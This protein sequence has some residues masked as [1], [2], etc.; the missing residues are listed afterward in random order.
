MGAQVSENKVYNDSKQKNYSITD[1]DD[2]DVLRFQTSAGQVIYNPFE[3]AVQAIQGVKSREVYDQVKT[4][5]VPRYIDIAKVP[6][7]RLQPGAEAALCWLLKNEVMENGRG[8]WPYQYSVDFRG[9][10]I[11]PPWVCSFGQSYA[12]L[13]FLLWFQHSQNSEYLEAACRAM[14]TVVTPLAAVGTKSFLGRGVFFEELPND[15]HIFNAHLLSLIVLHKLYQ[16]GV[17]EFQ[18]DFQEGIIGFEYLASFMDSGNWSNYDVPKFFDRQFQCRLS[19][20]LKELLIEKLLIIDANGAHNANSVVHD[21]QLAAAAWL[22]GAHLRQGNK[23]Y[24]FSNIYS[25]PTEDT[26]QHNYINFVGLSG[27]AQEKSGSME[28][29]IKLIVG[30]EASEAGELSLLTNDFVGKF[31]QNPIIPRLTLEKGRHEVE[32]YIPMRAIAPPLS[33]SYHQFHIDMLRELVDCTDSVVLKS[34]FCKLENYS[35]AASKEHD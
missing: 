21:S 3:V 2:S 19:R 32:I 18:N 33:P 29:A 10:V 20:N 27:L 7:P 13:A 35:L 14:R 17:V 15:T 23:G 24:F 4:F 22:S 9:D 6:D 12:A 25:E 30:Y 31:R 16:C 28:E 34:N 26:D 1:S 11:Q 8:I 5:L